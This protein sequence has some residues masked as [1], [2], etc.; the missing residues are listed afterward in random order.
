MMVELAF[1]NA[2]ANLSARSDSPGRHDATVCRRAY[3]A[4]CQS[5]SYGSS[6][7]SAV[8]L[9]RPDAIHD[10]SRGRE[11]D[12]CDD[13]IHAALVGSEHGD[14]PQAWRAGQ[15]RRGRAGYRMPPRLPQREPRPT[16]R[17]VGIDLSQRL[18]SPEVDITMQ[19]EH[20]SA[21][22]ALPSRGEHAA[23]EAQLS[24]RRTGCVRHTD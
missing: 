15:L 24:S 22:G 11:G 1:R 13:R 18:C 2:K 17:E 19:G 23:F 7:E 16:S 6:N 10:R 3:F 20:L 21:E 14:R 4:A 12:R 8:L 5:G 9:G